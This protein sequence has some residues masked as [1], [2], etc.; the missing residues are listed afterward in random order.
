MSEQ[1]GTIVPLDD[2]KRCPSGL[3]ATELK[4]APVLTNT[5]AVK[6]AAPSAVLDVRWAAGAGA[7]AGEAGVA[8]WAWRG[9][10]GRGWWV[11][12]AV[13]G[14]LALGAAVAASPY[15]YGCGYP[16][17]YGYGCGYPYVYIGSPYW[18]SA[19]AGYADRLARLSRLLG[20]A[21]RLL[22]RILN[23]GPAGDVGGRPPNLDRRK[24]FVCAASSA[25]TRRRLALT[26]TAELSEA[27]A[28][29]RQ[30]DTIRQD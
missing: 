3:G 30:S 10:W 14:G 23:K 7:V 11:P 9:G 29:A 17:G 22:G 28:C 16:Y 1:F 19:Y 6:T 26:S 27:L 4:A 8:V 25:I 5:A 13:I 15:Y 20:C 24:L 18:S 12:G 2:G 21:S